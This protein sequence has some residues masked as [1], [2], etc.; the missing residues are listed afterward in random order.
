M[1]KRNK[2]WGLVAVGALTAAAA[3]VIAAAVSKKPASGNRSPKDDFDDFDDL[4]NCC[5]TG[6]CKPGCCAEKTADGEEEKEDFVSWEEPEEVDDA[7][8]LPEEEGTEEDAGVAEET[9]G[10]DDAGDAEETDG[11]DDA[12]DAEETN[13]ADDAGVAEVAAEAPEETDKADTEEE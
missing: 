13:G 6:S 1:A 9:D 10:A 12:G 3:G 8:E 5:K 4:D 7:D 11:A 2:Y